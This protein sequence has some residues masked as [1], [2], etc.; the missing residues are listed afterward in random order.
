MKFKIFRG[1]IEVGGCHGGC[2]PKRLSYHWILQS[3]KGVQHWFAT[4]SETM[5]YCIQ[6]T[7]SQ[8]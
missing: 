8:L 2:G 4:F 3:P 1:A 6:W 7:R 5:H